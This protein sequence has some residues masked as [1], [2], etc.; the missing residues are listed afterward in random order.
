MHNQDLKKYTVF[1]LY[2]LEHIKYTINTEIK[3]FR[4]YAV[5]TD[6]ANYINEKSKIQ[7]FNSLCTKH[8]RYKIFLGL[9]IIRNESFESLVQGA[10][11]M[12]HFRN[13]YKRK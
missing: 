8:R 6:D 9:F 11:Y 2:I 1:V 10:W 3:L 4:F 13:K 7:R 5:L 12:V